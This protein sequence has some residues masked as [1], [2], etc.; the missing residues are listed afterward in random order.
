MQLDK[1]LYNEIKEFCELNELKTRDFI[2][3]ILKEAFLK[4]KYGESPFNKKNV[5]V[6]PNREEILDN[7][8]RNITP[9]ID[10]ENEINEIV[11]DNFF[12]FFDE[13]NTLNQNNDIQ[14]EIHNNTQKEDLKKEIKKKRKLK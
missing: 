4:E 1:E 11:S 9:Q 13:K 7:F 2:H 14:K 12:E 5:D 6:I 10:I 3:N 8:I